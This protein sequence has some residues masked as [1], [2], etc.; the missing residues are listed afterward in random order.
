M[1]KLIGLIGTA[2]IIMCTVSP[3]AG[4]ILL[5]YSPL[6][7]MWY[8]CNMSNGVNEATKPPYISGTQFIKDNANEKHKAIRL[9]IN[10]YSST[11][12]TCSIAVLT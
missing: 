1:D 4:I 8:F 2:T 12:L 9:R 3:G 6:Y 7:K 5:V 10:Q 11:Y